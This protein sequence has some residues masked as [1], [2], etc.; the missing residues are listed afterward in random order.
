MT[1][2]TRRHLLAGAAAIAASPLVASLPA[3]A[4][5]PPAGTQAPGF[6]RYKVGS[7]EITVVTDGVNR[8]P[9]TDEFV[10]NVKKE[11]VKAALA[12]AHMNPDVFVGPYNPIVI[13]TGSKLARRRHRHGSVR[14]H[15]EQRHDRPVPDQSQSLRHRRQCHRYGHH[16]ALPRRPHQRPAHGRQFAHLSQCRDSRAVRRAQILDGRRRDE[17]RV[18][19]L[20]SRASSRTRAVS[21]AAKFSSG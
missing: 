5:A 9:V 15:R 10:T 19:R 6:Y 3:F 18:H 14:L 1:E 2:L 20:A 17:P 8:L 12:A 11:E 21:S 13:N 7:I 4:A 16:L